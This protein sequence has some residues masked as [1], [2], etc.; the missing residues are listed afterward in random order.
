[1][2]EV[3]RSLMALD[4]AFAIFAATSAFFALFCAAWWIDRRRRLVSATALPDRSRFAPWYLG[5]SGAAAALWAAVGLVVLAS[6]G[7]MP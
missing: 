4:V 2:F 7:A 1:M 5:L 3:I 6:G